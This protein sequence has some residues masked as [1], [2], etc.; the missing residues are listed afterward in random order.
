MKIDRIY[1]A[2]WSLNGK[3]SFKYFC[4][5]GGAE[6]FCNKL[7]ELSDLISLDLGPMVKEIYLED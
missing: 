5:R 6:A 2:T 7:K 3:V 4:S 1:A